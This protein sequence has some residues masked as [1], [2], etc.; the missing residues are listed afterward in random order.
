MQTIL[1]LTTLLLLLAIASGIS[2]DTTDPTGVLDK[3]MSQGCLGA[4]QGLT[5]N[6]CTRALAEAQAKAGGDDRGIEEY[7]T[8]LKT[9]CNDQCIEETNMLKRKVDELC[10]RNEQ[11]NSADI[12]DLYL[13]NRNFVCATRKSDNEYCSVEVQQKLPM[14]KGRSTQRPSVD[15]FSHPTLLTPQEAQTYQKGVVDLPKDKLCTPCMRFYLQH[16]T[17]LLQTAKIP[18]INEYTVKLNNKCEVTDW[19]TDDKTRL[20]KV[21]SRPPVID[22][23]PNALTGP[24]LGLTPSAAPAATVSAGD[25][26]L[27]LTMEPDGC[28]SALARFNQST[29]ASAFETLTHAIPTVIK[30]KEDVA[31]VIDAYTAALPS[32]CADPCISESSAGL[33]FAARDACPAAHSAVAT[34]QVQHRTYN[35]FCA[36]SSSTH[37]R[38]L[39]WL[40]YLSTLQPALAPHP[41]AWAG[42]VSP[43]SAAEARFNAVVMPLPREQLCAPCVR[44]VL[45]QRGMLETRSPD[46]VVSDSARKLMARVEEQCGGSANGFMLDADRPPVVEAD[47]AGLRRVEEPVKPGEPE[48]PR[49]NFTVPPPDTAQPDQARGTKQQLA[50]R[51]AY[52][53]LPLLPPA[54]ENL[55]NT[56]LHT[57]LLL[58]LLLFCGTAAVL[59]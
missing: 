52:Q 41:E 21:H 7:K 1:S 59:V 13:V 48:D 47:G 28:T 4:L 18:G 16:Q 36:S 40:T 19:I 12:A 31:K 53:P 56:L 38:T 29:C 27:N 39:C 58:L 35:L 57:N 42:L 17:L 10:P 8:S 50:P 55:S 32:F 3:L 5:N 20:V 33:V 22:D 54:P 24:A 15:G 26:A 43:S 25:A 30:T 9:F 34:L 6:T 45:L 14:L 49:Q 46:R 2:A 11:V 51:P 23:T 37:P 44:F